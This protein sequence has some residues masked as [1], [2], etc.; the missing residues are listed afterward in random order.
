MKKL[1]KLISLAAFAAGIAWMLRDQL[2]PGPQEPTAHPPPFR[3]PPPP[4]EEAK[5]A[6]AA[7]P[8]GDAFKLQ[9][10]LTAVNGIG[11]VYAKRLAGAGIK[12]FS[13][14]SKADAEDLANRTDLP[15]DRVADWIRKASDL[16]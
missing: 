6:P 4:P 8:S 15:R 11:P 16:A 14:L 1:F 2:L 5:P 12:S 13:D 10:D 3:N 9:D 7:K